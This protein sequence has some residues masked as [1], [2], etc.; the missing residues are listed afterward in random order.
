M[1][2][3]FIVDDEE[4]IR[5]GIKNLIQWEDNGLQVI[6]TAE[7]GEEAFE[8]I[9]SKRPD[10]VL[11]DIRMTNMDGLSL[12]SSLRI[13][14]PDIKVIIITGHDDFDYAQRAL[15]LDI[16][17]FLIKPVEQDKLL[18]CLARVRD[19]VIKEK[20]DFIERQAI[21]VHLKESLPFMK[22]WFLDSI[23]NNLLNDENLYEKL[24]FFGID[25]DMSLF[26]VVIVSIDKVN[27]KMEAEKQRSLYDIYEKLR[28]TLEKSDLKNII[29][30]EDM[31]FTIIFSY[32]DGENEKS[33]FRRSFELASL[34]KEFLLYN[35]EG[36][37]TIGM[38]EIV[39]RIS[40][41]IYSYK[42]AMDACK[43]KFY[44]GEN[45]VIYI[46]DIEPV[47][48]RSDYNNAIIEDYLASA[49]KIGDEARVEEILTKLFKEMEDSREAVSSV[50]RMCLTLIMHISRAIYELGEKQEILFNHTDPWG[51]INSCNTLEQLHYYI[52]SIIKIVLGHLEYKRKS[53]NQKIIER[54]REIINSDCDKDI[55][56]ESVAENVCLSPAYL[57]SL[58]SKE[59]STTFKDYLILTRINRAR[60]LLKDVNL[61]I[62]EVSEKSG[63]TDSHYFSQIFKKYTG[64]TPIQY[65]N[66]LI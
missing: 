53:K 27:E 49:V 43:H 38:G 7:D 46:H 45:Q 39:N 29:F 13:I 24:R 50:K 1:V 14:M 32:P 47:K 26:Q 18:E 10:I 23:E 59:M 64:M 52:S 15:R 8:M 36:Y 31:L 34:I 6:G 37:F 20:Q 66:Q 3:V 40:N 22:T 4:I 28:S 2:T 19:L 63:Y 44:L 25:L 30:F 60:E 58:F 51:Q 61:K 11:T 65:R 9:K 55:S 42:G 62:Y 35:F 54:V 56:L 57:S 33:F 48:T 12:T 17:D 16:K 41:M 21:N 5:E